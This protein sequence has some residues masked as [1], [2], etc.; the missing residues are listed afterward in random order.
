MAQDVSGIRFEVIAD[1]ATL[2]ETEILRLIEEFVE[3]SGITTSYGDRTYLPA[4]DGWRRYYEQSGNRPSD[5]STLALAY[6][7]RALIS[8]AAI[9]KRPPKE[10]TNPELLWVQLAITRPEYHG[11]GIAGAALMRVFDGRFVQSMR[12]GYVIVRTPNPVVYEM[13]TRFIPIFREMGVEG[14]LYPVIKSPSEIEAIGGEERTTLA[15]LIS[16]VCPGVPFDINTFVI[17]GYYSKYGALYKK[18]DFKC[19]NAAVNEYFSNHVKCEDQ[20]GILIAVA[21]KPIA[22]D[23]M[24]SGP[25]AR[26]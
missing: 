3:L 21:Y 11:T 18:Y 2:P 20:E 26:A 6:A 5:Y 25:A 12:E 1:P 19:K 24:A 9:K 22:K 16:E 10:G 13:V 8:L 4:F 14:R 23:R 7:G 15:G 17:R